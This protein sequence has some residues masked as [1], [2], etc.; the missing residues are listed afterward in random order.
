MPGRA[1]PS[2]PPA[3]TANRLILIVEDDA[4]VREA[5][6][7]TLEDSGYE[8]IT[9]INGQEGLRQM[10]ACRP[11]AVVLDLVMPQMDGWQF[12][13]E[14]KH[15]PSL[16]TTPVVAIS[17][18]HSAAAATV[19]A[20]LYLGKPFPPGE[21][22]EAIA[23]VLRSHARK[24][25]LV[26]HAQEDRLI[27]LGT[28]A[29][30]VAHEINNP[31]TYV[32]LNLSAAAKHL[33][34]LSCDEHRAT[35]ERI[36]RL[37]RDALEG[38]DRIRGIVHG[39]GLFSRADQ[40][41]AAPVDVRL[42]LDAALRLVASELRMRAQVVTDYDTVPLVLADEARL[43]QVFVNLLSNAAQAILD[44]DPADHRVRVATRTDDEGRAVIEITDTG[45]GIPPHL[46]GRIFEP[47]F[48][49]KSVGQNSGLG[50]SISHGIVSALGGEITVESQ[51]GGGS[52]FRVSLPAMDRDPRCARPVIDVAPA[53]AP[54]RLR[55]LV[56][57]DEPAICAALGALLGD[58]HD[59]VEA[60]S[61]RE[62]LDRL[63]ANPAYDVLLCDVQMPGMSGIEL[64]RCV[65]SVW[66]EP[67]PAMILMTGGALPASTQDLLDSGVAVLA[68]PL[69][70]DRLRALV[71]SLAQTRA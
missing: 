19:D 41:D 49:T 31:L 23:T 55:I 57:D 63:T 35:I 22:V 29:A 47:F 50:L 30:G 5:L 38:S 61:A 68:K 11:A 3:S 43:G 27:A 10:R 1:H 8:V 62:A 2:S 18:S 58:E 28:L 21:I 53:A 69:A 33:T 34:A 25:D 13:L 44:G 40:P 12:R 39:I 46:L 7:E 48:T 45:T 37:L 66:P 14:Q 36:D 54:A 6:A 65:R 15:D 17:A 16:S 42:C 24:Q 32:Q 67:R 64:V 20:D 52:R 51:V 56:V 60:S 59:V 70:V 71:A 4:D 9:A 26:S